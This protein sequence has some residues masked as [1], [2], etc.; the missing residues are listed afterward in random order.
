MTEDD[1]KRCQALRELAQRAWPLD[2]GTDEDENDLDP[3][4]VLYSDGE[5][6][7]RNFAEED[8]GGLVIKHPTRALEAAEAAMR[9]LTGGS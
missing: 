2:V 6:R 4:E 9:V 5:V 1:L 7:I 3:I 8:E